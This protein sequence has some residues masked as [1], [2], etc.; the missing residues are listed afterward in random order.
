[1]P[2]D[3]DASRQGHHAT[4]EREVIVTDRGDRSG[5]PGA[6]IAVVTIAVL[7]VVGLFLFSSLRSGGEEI[8]EGPNVEV[9]SDINVDVDDQNGGG[10]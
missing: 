7:I 2:T 5:V 1:M 6:L 10:Q 8:E 3:P 9:P 4:H